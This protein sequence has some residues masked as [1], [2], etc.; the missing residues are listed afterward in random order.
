MAHRLAGTAMLAQW[1]AGR[2]GAVERQRMPP[3]T[4]PGRLGIQ[5]TC[6]AT[7]HFSKPP[8][9]AATHLPPRSAR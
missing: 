8:C 5:P 6:A 2:R 1:D 7:P 3:T 9:T 4:H